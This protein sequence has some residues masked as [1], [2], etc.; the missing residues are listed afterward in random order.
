MLFE[1]RVII[2]ANMPITKDIELNNIQGYMS[3]NSHINYL[4][5]YIFGLF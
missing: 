3:I 4:A 5:V 2:E 1:L